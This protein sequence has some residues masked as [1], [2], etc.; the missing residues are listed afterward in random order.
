M[1]ENYKNMCEQ[2]T[3]GSIEQFYVFLIMLLKDNMNRSLIMQKVTAMATL[4]S[5]NTKPE[6][7]DRC[8]VLIAEQIAR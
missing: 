7:F 8:T 5:P 2:N 3:K 4:H 1:Y 6:V